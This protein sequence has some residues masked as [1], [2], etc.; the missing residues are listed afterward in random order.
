M[1]VK[2]DH[3]CCIIFQTGEEKKK[4][5]TSLRTN[6]LN[7]QE[8]LCINIQTSEYVSERKAYVRL[9]TPLA[10]GRMK[11]SKKKKKMQ[12]PPGTLDFVAKTAKIWTLLL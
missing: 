11:L 10:T 3:D 12:K 2:N 1:Y 5:A 4:K 8:I 9:C 6:F 7:L